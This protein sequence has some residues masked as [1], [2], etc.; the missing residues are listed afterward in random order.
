MHALRHSWGTLLSKHRVAPRT[1]QAVM[2]HSTIDLTMN[3]DTD[4]KLLDVHA[5]LDARPLTAGC[6]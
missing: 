2:R 4:P 6:F 1:A 3:V 5:A